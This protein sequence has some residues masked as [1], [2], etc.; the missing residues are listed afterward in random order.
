MCTCNDL[1]E[2]YLCGSCAAELSKAR[3]HEVKF[4][5][6]SQRETGFRMALRQAGYTPGSV[7][8]MVQR[9]RE[10]LDLDGSGD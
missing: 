3:W 7:E 6:V 4:R 2:G 10:W 1:P 9:S 5:K 8:V